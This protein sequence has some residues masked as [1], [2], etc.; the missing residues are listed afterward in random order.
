MSAVHVP[1]FGSLR[2]TC[3]RVLPLPTDPNQAHGDLVVD[4]IPGLFLALGRPATHV[5]LEVV[6]TSGHRRH[7][8]LALPDVM[9]ALSMKAF[10]YAH[11]LAER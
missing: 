8:E 6:L 9:S 4:E 2:W 3:S 10:A 11:R 5:S 1:A 7:M